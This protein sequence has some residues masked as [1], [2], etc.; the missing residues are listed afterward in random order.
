MN[1]VLVSFFEIWRRFDNFPSV[2]SLNPKKFTD[3]R[4]IEIISR[5]RDYISGYYGSKAVKLKI[6]VVAFQKSQTH[7]DIS[8]RSWEKWVQ[9][10]CIF[11]KKKITFLEKNLN[12][13]EVRSPKEAG[14][15]ARRLAKSQ[16]AVRNR[17]KPDFYA[18]YHGKRWF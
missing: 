18:H 2:Y 3:F 5:Q 8:H 10:F 7:D 4:A 6:R 14:E 12:S 17:Q 13:E 1:N 15:I 9:S 11:W 16:G